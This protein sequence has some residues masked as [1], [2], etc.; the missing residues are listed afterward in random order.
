[1]RKV[2]YYVASTVD[3]F[4]AA[5]DG[6]FDVFI[7]EG[8]HAT[9]YVNFWQEVD[10]VLMGRKTYEVGLKFGVTSPYPNLQQYVFSR[11]MTEKPDPNVT[12]VR[13]NAAQVVRELKQAEGKDIWLCGAGDL[14]ATLFEAQLVDELL[15]KLNPVM[16]GAEGI[17][18]LGKVE[19]PVKM[20]LTNTK[21][22]SN[23]VMLLK[24]DVKY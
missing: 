18:L 24:Y 15:L 13:K 3:G 5:A 19:R 10:V 4:V 23:G 17:K 2:K 1:M 22:Y 14:A 9:D 8:E 21:R 20:E 6:S 16:L 12:L 11:T 7:Q